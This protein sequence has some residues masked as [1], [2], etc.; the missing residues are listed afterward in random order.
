MTYFE[1][2]VSKIFFPNFWGVFGGSLMKRE[3]PKEAIIREYRS[4]SSPWVIGYSGG[5]DSTCVL[6]LV[7]DAI[8][9]LPV[10][11]RHKKIVSIPIYLLKNIKNL[12]FLILRIR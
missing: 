10:E 1:K 8:I 3:S 2:F 9:E 4:S 5:K 7:W 11:K 12:K 6:Q